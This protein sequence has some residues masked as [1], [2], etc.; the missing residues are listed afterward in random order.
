MKSLPEGFE[1]VMDPDELADIWD[2]TVS[3]ANRTKVR[4]ANGREL[5]GADRHQGSIVG[6]VW[7]EADA[8]TFSFDVAVLPAF[9]RRGLGT[10]LS[11]IA[12]AEYA[13]YREI[14]HKLELFAISPEGEALARS[15]GLV[16]TGKALGGVIMEP[17]PQHLRLLPVPRAPSP[18]QALQ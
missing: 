2:Q 11:G 8:D 9:Q 1:A 7:T 13:D 10:Y 12:L 5:R 18:A 14:G 15:L 16:P 4:I 17:A 6:G 3:V